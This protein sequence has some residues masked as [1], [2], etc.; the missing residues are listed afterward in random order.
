M[1]SRVVHLSRIG[2]DDVEPAG[3]ERGDRRKCRQAALVFL[4]SDD[5]RGAFEQK[6]AGEAA[7]SRADLDDGHAFEGSGGAGDAA[8][9]I[10]IEQEVLAEALLGGEP[11]R[12]DHLAERG[13]SIRRAQA[14]SSAARLMASARRSA[15]IRLRGLA[16]P[17]P[18]MPKA[19]P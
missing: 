5:A 18:A 4:D 13:Q 14:R 10:E 1:Q 7:R 3:I 8:R 2:A 16:L 15:S 19:V 6:R 17:V 11:G 9:Q 12:A